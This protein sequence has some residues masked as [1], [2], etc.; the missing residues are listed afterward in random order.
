MIE[1]I[2]AAPEDFT[3]VRTFY[4]SLIDE[5]QHL[6]TFPGWEKDIYPT[7]AS[8][9]GYI[10]RGEMRLLIADGEIAAAVSLG[11]HGD[12]Y[13]RFVWPSGAADGEFGVVGLLAVHPRF[14]R[15]GFAKR[16]LRLALELAREQRLKAVRLDVA[17][18]NLPAE[19]LY[20]NAGFVYADRM[21][22]VFDDGSSMTFHLYEYPL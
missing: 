2:P 14:A 4:H 1:I 17:D 6:P 5:M 15:Q 11:R 19:H 21:T 16:M 8:L 10:D 12:G 7:D 18:N 13:D 20:V 9:R 3:R 22:T